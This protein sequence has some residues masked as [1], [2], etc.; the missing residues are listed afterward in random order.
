MWPEAVAKGVLTALKV[1]STINTAQDRKREND[2]RIICKRIVSSKAIT[3]DYDYYFSK[4]IA[5]EKH[6]HP[7]VDLTILWRDPDLRALPSQFK[8]L[9]V[10]VQ[11]H[12]PNNYW[13]KICIFFYLS[14]FLLFFPPSIR[15]RCMKLPHKKMHFKLLIVILPICDTVIFNNPTS[16]FDIF[17]K[18]NK[19]R[20]RKKKN[21][22]IIKNKIRKKNLFETAKDF[23]GISK[24]LIGE[25]F[26]LKSRIPKRNIMNFF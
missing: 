26:F 13:L 14:L 19:K 1:I 12:V 10:Y 9:T 23:T 5:V 21:L 24:V 22:F 18:R 3:H 16:M 4:C 2:I 20:L 11:H 17:K 8:E 6:R 15:T 25:V 7:A